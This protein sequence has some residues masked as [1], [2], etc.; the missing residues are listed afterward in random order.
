MP[1]AS[2]GK[3]GAWWG[4]SG[5][6]AAEVSARQGP[7]ALCAR[8]SRCCCIEGGEKDKRDTLRSASVD[9]TVRSVVTFGPGKSIPAGLIS[10][11]ESVLLGLLSLSPENKGSILP[12][13]SVGK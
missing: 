4:G 2:H 1:A 9:I 10:R 11:A 7:G 12:L 6:C 3:S 8:T 13:A 5:C